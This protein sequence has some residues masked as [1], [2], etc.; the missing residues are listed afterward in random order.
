MAEAI[1]SVAADHAAAARDERDVRGD[2]VTAQLL[3]LFEDLQSRVMSHM[4]EEATIIR[5]LSSGLSELT[6]KTEQ[7]LSAFPGGDA[8]AHCEYHQLLIDAARDRSEFWKKMRYDL[9]R[10]GLFGFLVWGLYALWKAF[11]L[12]PK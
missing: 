4:D 7:F 9:T 6:A 11:L 3:K 2:A 10:W 5:G 12:G 8:K 1:S